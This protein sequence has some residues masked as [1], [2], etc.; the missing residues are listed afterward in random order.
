MTDLNSNKEHQ[1][2]SENDIALAFV[3]AKA[4]DYLSIT[5]RAVGAARPRQGRPNLEDD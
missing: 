3:D 5:A 1:I 2:E 4:N